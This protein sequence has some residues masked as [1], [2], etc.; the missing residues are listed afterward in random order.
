[1]SK[2]IAEIGCNHKGDI[3]IAKQHIKIAA[4]YCKVD[5]VKFQKR[6]NK[7][8]LSE[9]IY[10]SPHPVP[11]NSY[12]STYGEHREFLEFSVA[13]HQEL[14]DYAESQNVI[15]S[16][17]VWDLVSAKEIAEIKPKLIKIP[18][19]TNLNFDLQG[20]LCDYYEG[21]I[22]V[23]TGMSTPEEVENIVSFYEDKGRSNDVVLYVCTSGY[24][25]SYEE[26]CL[27]EIKKFKQLYG[28]RVGHIAFSGHH[29]GIAADIAALT[30]GVDWIERHFTLD[31]T[32]KGTD[33]AASLEPDGMRK[34]VRDISNVK[35]AL[36]Y[37][38]QDILPIETVQRKKLKWLG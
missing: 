1:M 36:A 28:S 14:K 30:L 33:H 22:H 25:V 38:E 2:I 10:N 5:V 32:W 13:Q 15:Y 12:G 17:S 26:L 8:L 6:N 11:E 16:T 9:E 20:W 4:E 23:S 34:L 21:Q 35:L 3:E 29:L 7:T 37:K 27:L 19:A 31:R 18:S 24:P